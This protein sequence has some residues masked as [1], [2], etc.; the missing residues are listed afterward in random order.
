[1]DM[2]DNIRVFW[3][4]LEV[5]FRHP[6][7]VYSEDEAH[8]EEWAAGFI[9][10]FGISAYS[11]T[12]AC[13]IIESLLRS[14]EIE[15]VPEDAVEFTYVGEILPENIQEEVYGDPDIAPALEQPPQKYGI[16]FRSEPGFFMGE[17]DDDDEP[18]ANDDEGPQG[19]GFEI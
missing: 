10:E 1:M 17:D 12:E 16:W 7:P 4:E 9:M 11:E 5:R 18:E 15:I 14:D 6:R 2:T 19:E 3:I 13:N 8:I